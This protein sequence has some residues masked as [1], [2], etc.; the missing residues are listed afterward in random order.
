MPNGCSLRRDADVVSI[1]HTSTL[2]AR[3]F[4]LRY[5]YISSIYKQVVNSRLGGRSRNAHIYYV[6]FRNNE[7]VPFCLMQTW[8]QGETRESASG[9]RGQRRR[10]L[11]RPGHHQAPAWSW[12][13]TRGLSANSSPVKPSPRY[14]LTESTVLDVP[15]LS[16]SA[17]RVRCW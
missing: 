7:A 12:K 11:L 9:F 8:R 1:V 6:F 3:H 10:S 15:H 13:A 2:T 17:P 4:I 5:I 14:H 16:S